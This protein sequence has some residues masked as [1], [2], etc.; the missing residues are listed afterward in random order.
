MQRIQFNCKYYY[1][2]LFYSLVNT[3]AFKEVKKLFFNVEQMEGIG[4]EEPE[5]NTTLHI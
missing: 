5:I 1:I 3:P 2:Q 4:N